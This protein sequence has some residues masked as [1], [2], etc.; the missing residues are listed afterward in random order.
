[1][2]YRL[3]TLLLVLAIMPPF[4]AGVVRYQEWR[5]ERLWRSLEI[6]K[7]ERYS[8]LVAWRQV[9]E[10]IEKG[11]ASSAKEDAIQQQFYAARSKVEAARIA[12]E[13]RYGKT[14]AE[15]Q[16]AMTERWARL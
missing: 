1:M 7:R 9:R 13:A 3:C 5:D 6:A 16:R 14:D 2:R 15:L 8:A 11:Q 12:I 10:L 4:V